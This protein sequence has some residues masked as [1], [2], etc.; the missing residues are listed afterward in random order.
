V[1][2]RPNGLA[3]LV[4]DPFE[5]LANKLLVDRVKDRPHIAILRRFLER[6]VELAF[7]DETAPRKRITPAVRLL[8]VEKQQVLPAN[9]A[10]KLIKLARLPSDFRFLAH[11]APSRATARA[12]LERVRGTAVEVEVR[13]IVKRARR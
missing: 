7:R 6:E 8:R 10:R 4:A 2:R 13:D 9:L 11:H 5:L 12:L 3:V 1:L